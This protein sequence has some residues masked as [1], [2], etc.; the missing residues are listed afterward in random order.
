MEPSIVTSKESE[1]LVTAKYVSTEFFDP[2]L[3][4]PS[5]Y[6]YARRGLLPCVRLG[7]LVRFRKQEIEE[8]IANGGRRES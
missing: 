5:V 3:P 1:K 4:L 2:L 6:D 8:F 7:K